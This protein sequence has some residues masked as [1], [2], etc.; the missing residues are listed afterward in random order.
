M[1]VWRVERVESWDD[2][3]MDG[4]INMWNYVF[5]VFSIIG[6]FD[7]VENTKLLLC[8]KVQ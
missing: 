4:L 8:F 7:C 6:I 1:C 3:E 5:S 2:S